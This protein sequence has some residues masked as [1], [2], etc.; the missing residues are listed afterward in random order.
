MPTTESTLLLFVAFLAKDGLAYTTIKVY[1]AAIRNL[2]TS[3]GLHNTYS[4]QLTP[5]LEQVLQGIKKEQLQSR[6]PRIRLPITTEIMSRIHKVLS[7]SPNNHHNIMMWA[8]C[9]TAFFGFLRCSEFTVPSSN[10][11]EP[12][13]HLSLKDIALDNKTSPSLIRINIKQSKTDPF[14][15][16]FHLF[17]GC[18][19]HHICPVKALLPYLAVRESTEGPLFITEEGSPLTRHHFSTELS[20]ILYAAGLETTHYNTHSFH[21]GAANSAKQAGISDLHIKCVKMAEQCI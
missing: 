15:K 3:S 8:A 1:I 7:K 18:T 19:G 17:L 9:C 12:V 10:G 2:H 11:F 20:S 6:P 4:Q 14:R 21:I 16:G 5:Y 13:T